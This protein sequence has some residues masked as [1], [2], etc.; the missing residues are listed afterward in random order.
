[1]P[2]SNNPMDLI[3]ALEDRYDELTLNAS[4]NINAA[5]FVE[6]ADELDEMYIDPEYSSVRN[7]LIKYNIATEDEIDLVCDVVGDRTVDVL[8]DILN[9]RTGYDDI[10]TYIGEVYPK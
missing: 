10:N 8:N 7:K 9:V 4:S 1:M 5:E 2:R 3:N 6:D